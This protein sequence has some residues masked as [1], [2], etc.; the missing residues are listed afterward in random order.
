MG[1]RLLL[2]EDDESVIELLRFLLA[3]AGYDLI[4]AEDGLEGLLKLSSGGADLAI[5]DLMM[6]DVGGLRVLE[7]LMEEGDGE[8]PVPVIVITGSP[9]G[10]DRS[11]ELLPDEDVLDKPFDPKVL[12]AR[13]ESHLGAEH[14]QEA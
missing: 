6:P 13:I 11:R 1:G 9:L 4:V 14:G 5:V 12:L 2:I 8:L 7:Q 3:G 10:A